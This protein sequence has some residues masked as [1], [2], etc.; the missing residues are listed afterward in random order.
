ME[1]K[2]KKKPSTPAAPKAFPKTKFG[3]I[4]KM[5]VL[6]AKKKAEN[7]AQQAAVSSDPYEYFAYNAY[8]ASNTNQEV[9][10]PVEM[11]ET[12]SVDMEVDNGDDNGVN[13]SEAT[14]K[15]K[16]F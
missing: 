15:S 3:F 9:S 11:E 14:P 8:V 5:P 12:K 10:T 4:G 16:F 2:M 7:E 13:N 6:K 1:M